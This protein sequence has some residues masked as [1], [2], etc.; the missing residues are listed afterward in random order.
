MC[1]ISVV[2]QFGAVKH[3]GWI[4]DVAEGVGIGKN[5]IFVGSTMINMYA[6]CGLID[7]ACW[8]FKSMRERNVH[9]YSMEKSMS[10]LLVLIFT[11]GRRRLK[12]DWRRL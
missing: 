10:S 6:K 8:V 9:S 5:N 12:R 7:E 2:A 11:Q 3:A 4:W 1:L